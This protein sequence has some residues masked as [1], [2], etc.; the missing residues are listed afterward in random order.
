[1]KNKILLIEDD[2]SLAASIERVLVLADYDVTCRPERGTRSG[3]PMRGQ[4][5]RCRDRF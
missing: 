3:M 2:H 5:C 1:M 4:L